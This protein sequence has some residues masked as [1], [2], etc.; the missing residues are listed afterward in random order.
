MIS[1]ALAQKTPGVAGRKIVDGAATFE[2]ASFVERLRAGVERIKVKSDAVAHSCFAFDERQQAPAQAAAAL[3]GRNPELADIKPAPV[4]S[5]GDAA[6]DGA[7]VIARDD[8]QTVLVTQAI[9]RHMRAERFCDDR[10]VAFVSALDANS[11]RAVVH[12][13]SALGVTVA[14]C[15]F[16]AAAANAAPSAAVDRVCHAPVQIEAPRPGTLAPLSRVAD[17][18]STFETCRGSGDEHRLAL[19][20]MRVDGQA[21]LLTVDPVTLSTSLEDERFWSCTATDDAT[22][23]DTRFGRALSHRPPPSQGGLLRDEGITHGSNDGTFV[24]GDLCPSRLPLDRAFLQG[25]AQTGARAPIALSISGL[26]LEHHADDF[27]WLQQQR[28]AGTLDITWVMHSFTHPFDPRRPMSRDFLMRPDLD[29]S[30]EVLDTERLLIAQGETPSVFFRFPGLVANEALVEDLRR[31]HLI[32]LGADAWLVL[33][34]AAPR[35]GSIVLIH[36]NGNE[37]AGLRL[38]SRSLAANRFARPFRSIADA[39]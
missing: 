26:W 2:A 38:F 36:P 31:Y 10:P 18:V 12:R 1:Q 3:F 19:R 35:A 16:T 20:R 11:V 24:T 9:A 15:A 34:P 17:Y 37:P 29:L 33:S 30:H 28:R 32:A 23:A 13:L 5:A 39:P 27:R 14:L 8:R 21:L 25:F 4:R 22:E 6:D 7:V